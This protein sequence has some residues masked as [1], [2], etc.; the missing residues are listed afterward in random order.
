MSQDHDGRRYSPLLE[1]TR[2]LRRLDG[3]P[4]QVVLARLARLRAG[5]ETNRAVLAMHLEAV[6][7]ISSIMVDAV[8]DRP[9]PVG[10]DTKAD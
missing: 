10:P 4:D 7:E 3:P 9:V 5:L 1:L 8:R 6:R 2:A